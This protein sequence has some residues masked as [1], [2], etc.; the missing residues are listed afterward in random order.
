MEDKEQSK[1]IEEEKNQPRGKSPL[2][3]DKTYFK[4]LY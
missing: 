4:K 1:Q 2:R 3:N